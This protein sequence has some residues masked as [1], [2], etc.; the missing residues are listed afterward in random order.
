MFLMDQ[1]ILFWALGSGCFAVPVSQ[2]GLYAK[3]KRKVLGKRLE[4]RGIWQR[5]ELGTEYER[6]QTESL[7]KTTRSSGFEIG[8]AGSKIVETT[9]VLVFSAFWSRRLLEFLQFDAPSGASGW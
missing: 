2:A 8:Q 4:F 6:T 9:A 3:P 1:K 7:W 5:G